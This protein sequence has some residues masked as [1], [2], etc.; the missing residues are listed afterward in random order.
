MQNTLYTYIA[1]LQ[2]TLDI[3]KQL[4][5]LTISFASQKSTQLNRVSIQNT[6]DSLLLSI[7]L[8]TPIKAQSINFSPPISSLSVIE[9]DMNG[10]F[11][12]QVAYVDS[13]S[14]TTSFENYHN[15]LISKH[16]KTQNALPAMSNNINE[17][18]RQLS[19][20]QIN[21]LIEIELTKQLAR[22]KKVHKLFM[23]SAEKI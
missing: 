11:I 1:E 23:A 19:A 15:Q 18:A 2:Q 6:N 3:G 14:S 17:Y 12:I 13:T 8:N 22:L 7:D 21:T 20:K 9:Q 10:E 4:D 16:S 5:S